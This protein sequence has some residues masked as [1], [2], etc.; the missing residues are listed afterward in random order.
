MCWMD[1]NISK[2]YVS[3]GRLLKVKFCKTCL[4]IRPLGSSHCVVCNLCVERYD[5]HCPW[6]G[7]CI[8]RNNY[9]PFFMFL[10]FFNLASIFTLILNINQFMNTSSCEYYFYNGGLQINNSTYNI[11][12]F[13]NYKLHNC[14]YFVDINSHFNNQIIY[15]DQEIPSTYKWINLWSIKFSSLSLI[16]IIIIVK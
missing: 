11:L 16:I 3:K 7:N 15:G 5:H 6:V 14:T 9:K 4:I 2:Y 13:S 10:I 8:G 1:D 12:N